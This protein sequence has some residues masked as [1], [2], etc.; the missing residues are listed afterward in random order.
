MVAQRRMKK[1]PEEAGGWNIWIMPGPGLTQ[2][3]PVVSGLLRT[4]SQAYFG[5][6]TGPRLEE[7]RNAWLEAP[8]P[9]DEED[10]LRKRSSFRRLSICR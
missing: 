5:W 7:L 9:R 4:G 8:E 2:F 3:N 10:D 6:P 1:D